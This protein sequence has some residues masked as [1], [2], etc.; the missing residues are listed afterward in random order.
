MILSSLSLEPRRDAQRTRESV[1]L[2]VSVG[3]WVCVVGVCGGNY[4]IVY[5][6]IFFFPPFDTNHMCCLSASRR[7]R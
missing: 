4:C 5:Q 7:K 6:V 3:G 2:C 1:C